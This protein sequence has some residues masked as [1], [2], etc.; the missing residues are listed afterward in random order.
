M[1]LLFLFWLA[2]IS[3]QLGQPELWSSKIYLLALVLCTVLAGVLYQFNKR[4]YPIFSFP[5][6]FFDLKG[7]FYCLIVG[8]AGFCWAGWLACERFGNIIHP[9]FEQVDLSLKG[10]VCDL[11]QKQDNRWRFVFCV[12]NAQYAGKAIKHPE[13]VLLS[14]YIYPD[15]QKNTDVPEIQS[16]QRWQFDVRL[17]APHGSINPGGFDYELWLWS[18]NIGATGYIRTGK[19]SALPQLISD[20]RIWSVD[21][22]RE[23]VRSDIFK[24]IH[25][26]QEAGLLAALTLGDQ[27]AINRTD[28]KT[29]RI[30]GVAHL[31]SISG[32]HITMMGWLAYAVISWLWRRSMRLML[33]LPAH[34]AAAV[35]G[36]LCALFY[37]LFAGWGIPAQRTVLMLA[38]VVLLRLIGIRWPWYV[39]L[40]FAA[41]VVV[42]FDPWALLQA[43]FWLSFVAVAVLLLQS[44]RAEKSKNSELDKLVVLPKPSWFIRIV[45]AIINAIKELLRVQLYISLA[46]APLTLLLFQ[47]VSVI[48]LVANLFAIP[49]VTF[50]MVPL[51]MM[52]IL[53]HACWYI[54]AWAGKILMIFLQWLENAPAAVWEGAVPPWP[55]SLLAVLAAIAMVAPQLRMYYRMLCVPLML[56]A[57]LWRPSSPA[58]GEFEILALDVGQGSAVLVQTAHHAL[59][60]DTGAKF[61]AQSDA[62]ELIVVPTLRAM[63]IQPDKIVVSHIDSDHSGGLRSVH[64]AYPRAELLASAPADN[65]LWQLPF[66]QKEAC[67][68]GMNWVWDDVQFSVLHPFEVEQSTQAINKKKNATNKQSCVLR[69][70]AYQSGTE[71]SALLTGDI[72]AL[73]EQALID[74]MHVQVLK[75]NWLLMPHHGSKTSSS[76]AW[77]ASVKPQWAVAQTGYLN[78]FGHPHKEVL[79]RY[80]NAQV[81]VRNTVTCGAA[82][83]RSNQP[84]DMRCS[85]EER[86]RYWHH[87]IAVTQ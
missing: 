57:F 74:R 21:S 44:V 56:P 2:G 75:A 69:I 26:P 55:L 38:T 22:I 41:V 46:L 15:D 6:K 51:A 36:M 81:S 49:W 43:G 59:L 9:K 24:T 53:W 32:L 50:V 5:F 48:G 37:A 33:W 16:G 60:Y 47:Q 84:E 1:V 61:S 23:A 64:E 54:A 20:E 65:P 52:G 80:Q 73:Q 58:V 18:Q 42:A 67:V 85:R 12:N 28:W 19:T 8:V 25:D 31:V 27:Q 78:R 34:S 86:K 11:P 70:S 83:W 10:Y 66:V 29:F 3:W 30:T 63:G 14:W 4:A 45:R 39:T 87:R 79:I 68:A 40:L 13:K 17:K 7:I 77:I 62:G 71:I 76:D 82:L 35:G 72:E